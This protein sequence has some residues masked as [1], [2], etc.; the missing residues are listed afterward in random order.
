MQISAWKFTFRSAQ[1]WVPVR[2]QSMK[3]RPGR[4]FL[5]KFA[6]LC[7]AASLLPLQP[8]YSI[9]KSNSS[10]Q[11]EP[12]TD[13]FHKKNTTET[14]INL[15]TGNYSVSLT[16]FI[17]VSFLFARECQIRNSLQ[18]IYQHWP[19]SF[20]ENHFLFSVSFIRG[21]VTNFSNYINN[22]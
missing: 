22:K 2:L 4:D 14:G 9:L 19:S 18:H 7:R 21:I 13:H 16:Q 3:Y 6:D 8:N 1:G 12:I 15:L 20:T 5:A 10:W 17:V 11:L